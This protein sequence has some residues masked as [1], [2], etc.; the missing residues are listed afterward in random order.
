MDMLVKLAK[1]Q[2]PLDQ[3]RCLVATHPG[4]HGCPD[5][6]I[7]ISAWMQMDPTMP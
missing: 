7:S 5:S 1:V 2:K 4:S 6:D 3:V